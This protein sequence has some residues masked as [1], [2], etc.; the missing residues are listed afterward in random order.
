M[1]IINKPHDKLFKE[2]LSNIENSRSFME[3]YLPNEILNI[4]DLDNLTI[5]K[6]SY[7]DEELEEYFSDILFKTNINRKP[8]YIYFLFEHKSYIS[9][10]ISLQL[11]KYI[12]K[13]WEQKLKKEG[14]K[15]LPLIIPMVI[16]HGESKW[17]LAKELLDIIDGKEELTEEIIKYIPNYKYILYDLSPYGKE[18]IKGNVN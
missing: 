10:T 5:E 13:I 3:N 18:E 16:Y 12:I 6:D 15:K 17:N 8:G 7:I 2:V 14:Q 1:G 4:I 9:D 11:L